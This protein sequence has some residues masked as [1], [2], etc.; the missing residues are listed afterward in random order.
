[1]EQELTL[2]SLAGG[3]I[4]EDVE[5]E[6]RRIREN[7][8]DVN[9]PPEKVRELTIKVKFKPHKSNRNQVTIEA[10]V[11]SRLTGPMPTEAM[12]MIGEDAEGEKMVEL[13]MPRQTDIP[14]GNGPSNV[15]EI[16]KTV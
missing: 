4:M 10:C 6:I 15:T 2:A 14:F 11:G 16:R 1:M 8:M 3:S 12:A 7:I 13:D 5:R 9:T